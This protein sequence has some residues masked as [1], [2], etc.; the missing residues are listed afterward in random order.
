MKKVIITGATSGIG[1]ALAK[2]FHSRGYIVGI[3]GRREK[4]L[5]QLAEELGHERVFIQTLDVTARDVHEKLD[6]LADAMDGVDIFVANA[7]VGYVTRTLDLAKDRHIIDV[8][9]TGFVATVC[10][11]AQKFTEQKHGHIVGISSVASTFYSGV[12]AAYN[13]SKAFVCSYLMGIRLMFKTQKLPVFVT[14]VRPGFVESEMVE[15]QKGMFWVAKTSVAAYQMVEAV[16]RKK[17]VVYITSRWRIVAWL[18][19]MA[20]WFNKGL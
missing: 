7:G 10:W 19:T 8:N 2:E 3:T 20:G 11:A 16:E 1:Y 15:G 14:E 5:L 13:A 12:T 18:G 9:V 17:K 4:R 6:S